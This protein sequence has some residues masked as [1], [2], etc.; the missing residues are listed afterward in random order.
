MRL[1]WNPDEWMLKL[2]YVLLAVLLISM[3]VNAVRAETA[4]DRQ[5]DGIPASTSATG[6]VKGSIWAANGTTWV[7]F[8]LSTNGYILSIDTSTATGLKWIENTGGGGSG[9]VTN[10]AT[11]NG[12]S[13]GPITTTGTIDLRL[14]ATGTLSKTLGVGTNELGIA[15]GGILN[16]HINAAAA[17]GWTKLSKTGSSLADFDTRSASDLSS[18]TLPDARFPATLPAASGV[19]LTALNATQL[20]SGT[21][22]DARFPATLPALSGVN[23]TAL[24]GSNIASGTVAIARGGTGAGT[25]S[26]AFDALSPLTT[27]GD[28][29]YYTTTNARLPKGTGLQ[30]LRMNAGATAPEWFSLASTDLSDTANLARSTNNLSFFAATTS[31][32]LA[33]V[34]S[35]ETGSGLAVFNDTPTFIAPIL[36]TPTSGN[37]ANCTFPTLNQNTTGSAA[38]LTTPRAIYGN[39]FDG[40]AALA[41]I[42]ASTYG[43]TGNGFT[44]FTGPATT[45]KT[46]TLPDS[47]ETLLYAG[48][49]LGTP[50]SGTLT[51]ATGLPIGGLTGLGANVGAFL[52]TPSSAN[53]LAALTD[54]TGSGAA[55]FGTSPTIATPTISGAIAFPDGV[56]QTFNPNAANSGIN[57][58][59]TA[60][61]IAAALQGDLYVNQALGELRFSPSNGSVASVALQTNKL[62]AFAPTTSAELAT[63]ISDEEG[64]G[65]GFVRATSPTLTTPVLGVA[66]ATSI[67]KVAITAPAA[68]ATLTIADGKTLTASN[69]LTFT[70]TDSSSVAFGAGGTVLYNGGALGTPSSGT[71]TN[72]TGLPL[73]TGVTGVLPTAN[74]GSNTSTAPA[75]GQILV[76][77]S[78]SAYAPR[79]ISGTSAKTSAYTV[80]AADANKVIK[81]DGSGGAF[82]VTLTAA[83]TL[84]DGFVVTIL[85]TSADTATVTGAITI[86]ANGSETIGGTALTNR[87]QSKNGYVTL[88]CDGSN[89]WVVD[90]SDYIEVKETS[91][92]NYASSTQEQNSITINVPPGSWEMS[93][94]SLSNNTAGWSLMSMAISSTSGNST[95]G[96]EAGNNYI[97]TGSVTVGQGLCIAGYR[98][99]EITTATDWYMKMRADFSA[100]NPQWRGRFSV[101]RIK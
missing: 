70:G 21:V 9:T 56:S 10:I 12:L 93:A 6:V 73:T 49:A 26:A 37:L 98:P 46:F 62:S 40:S 36:G 68:S 67:N 18:G 2:C 5:D 15:S 52:A 100:A 11:G 41:Q 33:G 101:V 47:S 72:L 55:V 53:L 17:I 43:G 20:T 28:L 79:A 94:T 89:W 64:S 31:A 85:K 48:G 71:A 90:V 96:Y 45:E 88:I 78:T 16:A 27:A 58:G 87:L 22:P 7:P 38:T 76:A 95:S 32:Q 1:K 91:V 35:N 83:A 50:A 92:Q 81:C 75:V 3:T 39:N 54:E 42:I 86:D 57:V 14:D 60:N 13:G 69:T 44:K 99:A 77:S 4:A 65:G 63:V 19:N 8:S 80:A 59:G 51:N 29:L 66:T 74:G 23:L 34:L 84:G 25:A 24:N 82:T 97:Y 61:D 30:L